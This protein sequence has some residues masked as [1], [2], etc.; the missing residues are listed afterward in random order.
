MAKIVSLGSVKK[1]FLEKEI[2]HKKCLKNIHD[3]K[4]INVQTQ[5]STNINFNSIEWKL[6]IRAANQLQG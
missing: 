5:I 4:N 1:K 2:K 3:D 6:I